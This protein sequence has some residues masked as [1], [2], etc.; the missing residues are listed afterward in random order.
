MDEQRLQQLLEEATVDCYD[1][2]EEFIGVLYTLDERLDFP[3][4]AQVL[5]ETVEVLGL[6]DQRSSLRCGIIARVRKEGEEYQVGL[7]ELS[8]LD[9]DPTSAQ[10]LAMYYY[11]LDL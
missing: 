8:F 7:S 10:W 9:P 2:Y 5:G 6:D 4:R 11:W 1:E 3:L